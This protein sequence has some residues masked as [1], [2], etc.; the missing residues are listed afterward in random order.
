MLAGVGDEQ[1]EESDEDTSVYRSS[2]AR[3]CR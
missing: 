3:G 2:D 1:P